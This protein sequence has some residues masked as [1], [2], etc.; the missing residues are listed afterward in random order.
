MPLL[1][2]AKK[3]LRQDKVRTIRNKKLKDSFKKLV[4]S[5][6]T[7]KTAEA[8]SKAFSSVDKAVKHKIMHKN[9]AARMKAALTKVIEGKSTTQDV[10]KKKVAKKG[11][12]K[13]ATAKKKSTSKKK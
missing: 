3:K 1:K 12:T 8:L 5:A 9:K 11:A 13:K 7:E 10:V 2:H 4:K 6:R